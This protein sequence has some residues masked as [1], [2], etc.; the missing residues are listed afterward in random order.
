MMVMTMPMS[1]KERKAKAARIDK[2][3]KSLGKEAS[4]ELATGMNNMKKRPQK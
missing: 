2:H 3:I 4:K 1:E